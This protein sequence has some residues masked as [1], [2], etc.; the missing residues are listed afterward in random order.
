[1]LVIPALYEGRSYGVG[2]N[3]L[4]LLAAFLL[5]IVTFRFFENPIRR[6]R[7]SAPASLVLAPVTV[8]AVVAVTAVTISS[9]N[10]R[11]LRLEAAAASVSQ[12][13]AT[14]LPH[15]SDVVASRPLPV[16]AAAVKAAARGAPIPDGLRPPVG[17]LAKPEAAYQF[18]PGCNAAADEATTHNICRMG[19][20]SAAKTI[21]VF[22]DSHAQTWMPTIL[23]MAKADAWVVIP[24]NKSGCSPSLWRGTGFPGTP[25]DWITRCHK[26]YRWA[27][28]RK[29]YA[30]TSR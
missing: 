2:P 3:L 22:G 11:S 20:A 8:A 6:A 19:D 21:V 26:W 23:A 9:L 24:I 17:D 13:H 16:I 18:P 1:M 25:S 29:R 14:R 15:I 27:G 12:A 28:R 5:S 10:D 7:W 4:F 30:L